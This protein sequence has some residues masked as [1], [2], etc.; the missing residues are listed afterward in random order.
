MVSAGWAHS[1][2]FLELHVFVLC[3]F[4]TI[5]ISIAHS[6]VGVQFN[7]WLT[8]KFF[9]WKFDQKVES[10]RVE[11][12]SAAKM[13]YTMSLEPK[14]YKIFNPSLLRKNGDNIIYLHNIKNVLLWPLIVMKCFKSVHNCFNVEFR[15]DKLLNTDHQLAWK[16]LCPVESSGWGTTLQTFRLLA[17]PYSNTQQIQFPPRATSGSITCLE[18]QILS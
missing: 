10:S 17:I 15:I 8:C 9:A 2:V 14:K 6:N 3:L 11:G 1:P 5:S 18:W 12:W 7:M 4:I 13:F 16:W